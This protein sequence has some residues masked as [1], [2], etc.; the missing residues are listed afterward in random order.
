RRSDRPWNPSPRARRGNPRVATVGHR[1]HCL[2]PIQLWANSSRA[3]LLVGSSRLAEHGVSA[4]CR[5]AHEMYPPTLSRRW[6]HGPWTAPRSTCPARVVPKKST[7][8]ATARSPAP[9]HGEFASRDGGD[10]ES[11]RQS[12]VTFVADGVMFPAKLFLFA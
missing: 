12:F 6:C 1:W 3:R 10:A 9:R 8:G 7:V 4:R 5:I 11:S 2:D